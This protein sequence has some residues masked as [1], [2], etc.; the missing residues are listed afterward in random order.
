M[1]YRVFCFVKISKIKREKVSSLLSLF[2]D[3][4]ITR[5]LVHETMCVLIVARYQAQDINTFWQTAHG[6]GKH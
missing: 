3:T 4:F 5:P 1:L 2:Y 6:D